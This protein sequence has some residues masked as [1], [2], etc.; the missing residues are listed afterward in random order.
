MIAG[1][2]VRA[3]FLGLLSLL[4]AVPVGSCGDDNGLACTWPS[5][6]REA[7]SAAVDNWRNELS[8]IARAAMDKPALE[9]YNSFTEADVT[10]WFDTEPCILREVQL[11]GIF[12][13]VT[14]LAGSK[15]MRTYLD[16]D[17]A[18]AAAGYAH[19]LPDSDRESSALPLEAV[20]SWYCNGEPTSCPNFAVAVQVPSCAGLIVEGVYYE[21]NDTSEEAARLHL[22]D[23]MAATLQWA[24]ERFECK[25]T[26][27]PLHVYDPQS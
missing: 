18:A 24:E 4:V 9:T 8:A 20:V 14:A 7:A 5:K 3:G 19:L 23:A 13:R 1:H 25:H 6:E 26:S 16:H 22:A 27:D 17:S 2:V 12:I 10:N 21:D 15:T 11:P